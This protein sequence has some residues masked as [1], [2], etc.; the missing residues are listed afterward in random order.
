MFQVSRN[1][2]DGECTKSTEDLEVRRVNEASIKLLYVQYKQII[3]SIFN[4]VFSEYN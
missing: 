3:H 4:S 2:L 1:N